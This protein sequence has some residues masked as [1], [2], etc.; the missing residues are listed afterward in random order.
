MHDGSGADFWFRKVVEINAVVFPFFCKGFTT[1]FEKQWKRRKWK[2]QKE[3]KI[4]QQ[5][6]AATWGKKI[7]LS[8]SMQAVYGGMQILWAWHLRKDVNYFTDSRTD[9]HTFW[10]HT[11]FVHTNFWVVTLHK[12]FFCFLLNVSQ[13]KNI[14]AV[15]QTLRFPIKKETETRATME[16]NGFSSFFFFWWLNR[17]DHFME[18]FFENIFMFFWVSNTILSYSKYLLEREHH[19]VLQSKVR[20]SDP[21]K[22]SFVHAFFSVTE[23][24]MKLLQN[25]IFFW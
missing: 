14:F 18:N 12:K 22:G 23:K 17:F 21:R 6:I 9:S 24:N 10:K 13:F 25:E 3:S 20:Q 4:D 11:W 15:L 5:P 16:K 8:L 2:P 19:F 7:T 1:S